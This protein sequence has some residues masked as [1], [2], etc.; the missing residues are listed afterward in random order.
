VGAI[1]PARLID[2]GNPIAFD[3]RDEQDL[4]NA[5]VL[6]RLVATVRSI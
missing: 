3:A 6:G 2:E 5:A 4:K 1:D